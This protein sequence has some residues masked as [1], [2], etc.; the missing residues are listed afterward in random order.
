MSPS[1]RIFERHLRIGWGALAIFV[2]L[3]L[4]LETLHAFKVGAYLDVENETRRLMWRLA[5]AH[6]T[7][8]AL[9]HVAYALTVRARPSVARP[10]ASAGLTAALVL[11]PGGFFAGGVAVHGGD[12]SPAVLAVP[13]GFVALVVALAV[14][15]RSLKTR[16]AFET[17]EDS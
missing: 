5:H 11:I 15:F 1:E 16:G 10:L 17:K 13:A 9:V 7:L 14:I 8:L 4:A 3:G 6:G 2:V 12:P